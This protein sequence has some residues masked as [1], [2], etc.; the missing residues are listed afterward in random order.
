[1]RRWILAAGG[2]ACLAMAAAPAPRLLLNT[3]ASVPVGLYGLSPP[4]PAR[5]GELVVVRPNPALAAFLDE[6]GWLPRGVPLIKPVGAMAGQSVCRLGRDLFIDGRLAARALDV[7]GHGRTLPA[8][9]GCRV[10]GPGEVLL[11]A[12]AFGSLDGR[13]FGPNPEGEILARARPLL[14]ARPEAAR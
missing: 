1:M 2:L 13:Y 6:G 4:G 12:P 8:W 5:Q 3:T 7:D 14:V 9:S 11:L 10:L